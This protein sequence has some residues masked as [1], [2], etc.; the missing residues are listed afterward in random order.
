MRAFVVRELKHP[1]KISLKKEAPV[2]NPEPNQVLVDVFSTGLNF[3][4][5]CDSTNSGQWTG[6]RT[7]LDPAS[8]RK[9]SEQATFTLHP[10]YRI[11]W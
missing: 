8:P 3:F 7:F 6:F 4:D 9:I 2:P 11:R 1:S 5:V 10:R